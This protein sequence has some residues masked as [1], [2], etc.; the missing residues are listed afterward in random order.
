MISDFTTANRDMKITLYD[1]KNVLETKKLAIIQD[2]I[3]NSGNG[4]VV[5]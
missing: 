1:G 2:N 3:T 4:Q 5:I